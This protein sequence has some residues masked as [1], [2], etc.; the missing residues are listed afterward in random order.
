[1]GNVD[2]KPKVKISITSLVP[3]DAEA[4]GEQEER[5]DRA[6]AVADKYIREFRETILQQSDFH[7]FSK[8]A[9]ENFHL[10]VH[11]TFD[12]FVIYS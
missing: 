10:H 3:Q 2:M 8:F 6:V 11:K 7:G 4:A 9:E 1:M 12:V 5:V